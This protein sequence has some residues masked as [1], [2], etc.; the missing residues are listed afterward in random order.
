MLSP[1][2]VVTSANPVLPDSGAPLKF[3]FCMLKNT[4]QAD[5]QLKISTPGILAA[6]RSSGKKVV[7]SQH[8]CEWISKI[9]LRGWQASKKWI[10]IPTTFLALALFWSIRS[11]KCQKIARAK[12]FLTSRII[13]FMPINH[14]KK[15]LKSIHS[16]V[17]ILW[18]LSQSF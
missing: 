14:A 12:N 15:F 7:K 6:I 9:L 10:F 17:V 5:F 4:T 13:F 2:S 16:G 18:P 11:E 1:Y 8:R 3:A